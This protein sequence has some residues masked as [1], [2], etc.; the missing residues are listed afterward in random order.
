MM[1]TPSP[2]LYRAGV[3]RF[4]RDTMKNTD[5]CAMEFILS[6]WKGANSGNRHSWER[7]N[8]AVG[9]ACRL[10]ARSFE[11]EEGDLEKF[12]NISNCRYN[13]LKCVGCGG[14]ES[15]YADAVKNENRTFCVEYER[16]A[17]REPIIVDN[18]N[19]RTRD[20]LCI[21]SKFQWKD[22]PVE[23]TSFND[24]GLAIACSYQRVSEGEVCPTCSMCRVSAQYRILHR[25]TISAADVKA[26][27]ARKKTED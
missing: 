5:S 15:L 9:E 19:G 14:L 24:A 20:R 26:E 27:R 16:W 10:A 3:G 2:V 6:A 7:F 11:W 1:Y 18:V 13:I 25:Y 17:Q 4:E 8:R 12:C 21:G 23:V 22:E